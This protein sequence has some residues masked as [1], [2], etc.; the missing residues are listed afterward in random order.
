MAGL[1]F[2]TSPLLRWRLLGGY[3]LRD[4]DQDG[5]DNIATSLLEGQFEWLPTQKMTIYGTVSREIVDIESNQSGG[6]IETSIDGRM[7]YEIYNNIVLSAG[8]T[9]RDTAFTEENRTDRTYSARIGLEYYLNKNW[10]FT[11]QYEHE[12]RDSNL[13]EFDMDSNRFMIGAKLR[14]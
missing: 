8:A 2:E 12:R 10:L 6:S 14:F 11:F 5:R 1:A 7:D 3:G 13:D 9:A 4:Y